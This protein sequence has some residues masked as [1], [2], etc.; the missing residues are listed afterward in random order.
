[1]NTMMRNPA[2]FYVPSH[3]H[4]R[5]LQ[6]PST[7]NPAPSRWTT[8][9]FCSIRRTG[10]AAWV[11]RLAS[12]SRQRC[13]S[14][15]R[16]ILEA[17][18]AR[19]SVCMLTLRRV[20][21]AV[22]VSKFQLGTVFVAGNQAA[23]SGGGLAVRGVADVH[24]VGRA[25]L[26]AAAAAHSAWVLQSALAAFGVK[27]SLA[28]D[29]HALWLLQALAGSEPAG[30]P[31]AAINAS[32]SLFWSNV[33]GDGNGGELLPT[34][35]QA[36]ALVSCGSRS[37]DP[38]QVQVPSCC[39]GHLL[40]QL[41]WLQQQRLHHQ[42]VCVPISR[43]ISIRHVQGRLYCSDWLVTDSGQRHCQWLISHQRRRGGIGCHR[44]WRRLLRDDRSEWRR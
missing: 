12:T 27:P 34:A 38:C 18:R 35:F 39:R 24:S 21:C 10:P 43:D 2:R 1:M 41:R 37:T 36:G 20:A 9:R 15:A 32:S 5:A 40:C 25:A 31:A 11:A 6:V 30:I 16:C 4:T 3:L 19:A 29:P 44:N 23:G 8:R 13:V 28:S 22:Q 7:P 42:C 17:P 26:I 33:A 14:Q